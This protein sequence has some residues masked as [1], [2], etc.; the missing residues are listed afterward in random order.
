MIYVYINVDLISDYDN[1]DEEINDLRKNL[2]PK[3]QAL[4]NQE[5]K[6]EVKGF[7]LTPLSKEELKAIADVL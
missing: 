5:H 6:E 1:L 3:V 2:K 4:R 7:G